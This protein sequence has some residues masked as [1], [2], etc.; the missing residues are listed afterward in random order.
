[1]TDRLVGDYDLNP[2]LTAEDAKKRIAQAERFLEVA[3]REL[4]AA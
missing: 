2:A 4:R 3:R 1:M